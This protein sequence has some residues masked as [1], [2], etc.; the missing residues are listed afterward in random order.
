MHGVF[1]IGNLN[2]GTSERLNHSLAKEKVYIATR[3]FQ[4]FDSGAL[5]GRKRDPNPQT[6]VHYQSVVGRNLEGGGSGEA[7][8]AAP[9]R[10]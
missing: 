3:A 4:L 8:K 5:P 9:D 2:L 10:E 7:K 6:Y 1:C